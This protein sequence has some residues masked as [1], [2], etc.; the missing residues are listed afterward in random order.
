M[1]ARGRKRKVQ[2]RLVVCL[3]L[4]YIWGVMCACGRTG[5]DADSGSPSG[6]SPGGLDVWFFACSEDA[7]SILL[8]TEEADILIDTGVEE[9]AGELVEKLERLNVDQIDLLI[10]THPDQDHIGGAAALLEAF[11]V[12]MVLETSCEKG[13]ELQDDLD[14][15]LEREQVELPG[16]RTSFAFGELELEVYPPHKQ[17][18]DNAN[19]YSIA[20]LA[21]YEGKQF[22]FA[23][24][25]KKK[26]IR[27]LL[28]EDLPGV[29]VYKVSH[30]GRD[31][32]ASRDLILAL[33][34]AYA[35]VT[36][37]EPEEK[38]ADALRDVGAVVYSTYE[39]DVH[40]TVSEGILDVE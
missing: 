39:K 33:Q 9:D 14:L 17:H 36:A 26:R 32:G 40:F 6:G 8:Q 21:R 35:V 19:N 2:V 13:S 25:A 27:E 28:E 20:V 30:H 15:L 29:D 23:G 37:K 18:Y 12:G 31:N 11:P 5:P 16:R 1:C 34:P 7:D 4:F 38:T 24:D 10:L 3:F 22:F